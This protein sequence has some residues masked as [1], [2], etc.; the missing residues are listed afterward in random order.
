MGSILITYL[1][2]YLGY[3]H[4][5]PDVPHEN[6]TLLLDVMLGWLAVFSV[7]GFIAHFIHHKRLRRQFPELYQ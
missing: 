2:Y 3:F 1:A 7:Y 5:D 4:V 6:P